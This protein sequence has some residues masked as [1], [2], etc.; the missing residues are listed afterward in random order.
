MTLLAD[1][2]VLLVREDVDDP[3]HEVARAL[4]EGS[5]PV[6]TLDLA[7]YEVTNVAI[8]AW[9]DSS[10]A[11][12]LRE[13][14]AALADDGGLVRAD[15]ALVARAAELTARHALSAYDA[16][17]VAAASV[18]DARLVSCDVRDLVSAGLALSPTAAL[19]CHA[20]ERPTE[21]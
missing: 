20:P 3:H 17:Y 18:I 12:R 15:E 5:E 16:A 7:Y 4:L 6:A 14:V 13:T 10:A 8:R 11:G 19:A 21:P 1:A 9:D 2:S